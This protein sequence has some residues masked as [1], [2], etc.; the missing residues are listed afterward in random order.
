M[1]TKSVL[2]ELGLSEGEIKVYLALLKLGAIPVSKIK[3][4]TNLHR[5]TIYDFL[6]KLINKGLVSYVIKNNVKYYGATHPEKLMEF[7]NEK[8]NHLKQVL[9]ELVKLTEFNR[10]EVKVEVYKGKEGLKTVMLDFLRTGIKTGKGAVGMGIDESYYKKFLPVFTEQYQKMLEENKVH[11]YIL[12]KAN[13]QYLFDQKFA[14]YKFIPEEFFSPTSTFVCGNKIQI[15]LWEPSL[16]TLVIENKKLAEAWKKHFDTLWNQ[17]S[18]IFRGID[19]VKSVFNGVPQT[20]KK[21]DEY[22]A[23]G[24]PPESDQFADFF[25][26]VIKRV[27]ESR[28]TSRIIIDERAKK[29]IAIFKKY[30]SIMAKTLPKEHMTPAEI[31]IYGDNLAIV[32]WSKIPQAFV[33]KNKEI[34]GSFKKYFEIMWKIAK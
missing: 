30:S 2:E 25:D 22:L 27:D 7:L 19:E 10:E 31:D 8:Q 33:I 14:H 32:L 4:E 26:D 34:A 24:I 5:T 28:A 29:Q 15:V 9:P 17:E 23:F 13:P 11:E 21:G 12:T 6:E 1:D 3:E 20:L 18:M 16:T